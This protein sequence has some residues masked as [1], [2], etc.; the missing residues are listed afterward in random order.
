MNR[1][2]EHILLGGSLTY[3]WIYF[4]GLVRGTFDPGSTEFIRFF[5]LYPKQ[6]G[7]L[8]VEVDKGII[9]TIEALFANP[10]LFWST[11]MML[12]LLL[13][14]LSC[15]CITVCSRVI[16]D[17]A[18]LAVSSMTGYYM[19]IAGWTRGLGPI[20]PSCDAYHLRLGCG[21]SMRGAQP[22]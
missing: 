19:A 14:S 11:V 15:A 22:A 8:T 9:A 4:D 5:D 10:L 21:W 2:A 18:I 3:T 13:I 20:S 7:L 6:D 1:A 17:P 12:P 16:Q